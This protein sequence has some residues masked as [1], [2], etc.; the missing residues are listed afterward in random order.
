MQASSQKWRENCNGR[1]ISIH[2]MNTYAQIFERFYDFLA[3]LTDLFLFG[4]TLS[5]P[6]HILT[7]Y[8][9]AM[10]QQQRQP[11]I[12]NYATKATCVCVRDTKHHHR[13]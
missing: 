10:Q 3:S 8:C 6:A 9:K 12:V 4:E 11:H 1:V 7:Q 13:E 2:P 5:S